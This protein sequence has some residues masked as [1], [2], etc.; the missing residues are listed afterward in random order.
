M[1][2]LD[3]EYPESRELADWSE[4]TEADLA[5]LE[6]PQE[7]DLYPH[8]AEIDP[9]DIPYNTGYEEAHHEDDEDE[10]DETFSE[11]LRY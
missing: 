9:A 5:D 4:P 11:S 10:Y 3:G 7:D 6:V 2:I 8:A 1:S